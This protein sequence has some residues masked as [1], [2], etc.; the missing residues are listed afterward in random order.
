MH[1]SCAQ[2]A[3]WSTVEP[4]FAPAGMAPSSG[5]A[6]RWFPY[7]DIWVDTEGA[8]FSHEII[9]YSVNGQSTAPKAG[10]RTNNAN[11]RLGF[12]RQT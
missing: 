3:L 5:A 9:D 11:H 4:V 8:E 12:A 6:H 10:I 1:A 2:N 7:H